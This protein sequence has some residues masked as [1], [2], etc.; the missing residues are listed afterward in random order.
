MV[1]VDD[2][3]DIVDVERMG[4]VP[5]DR[6]GDVLEQAGELG[7]VVARDELARGAAF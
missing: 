1:V 4:A 3:I 2:R 5:V 7:L 6:V